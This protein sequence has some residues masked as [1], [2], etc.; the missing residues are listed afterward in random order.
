[1]EPERDFN[2]EEVVAPK[3]TTNWLEIMAI[4]WFI[5]LTLYIVFMVIIVSLC[6]LVNTPDWMTTLGWAL[7]LGTSMGCLIIGVIVDAKNSK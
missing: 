6:K 1:M 2:T 3:P 7:P 5:L 4:C